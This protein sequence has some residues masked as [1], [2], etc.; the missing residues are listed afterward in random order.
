MRWYSLLLI[1]PVAPAA[2][3]TSTCSDGWICVEEVAT[4]N[5][6]ELHARNL[7]EVPVTYTLTVR[8]EGADR[9]VGEETVTHTLRPHDRQRA[10]ALEADGDE[11][12]R[13]YSI[14]IAWSV[15]DQFANHDDDYVYALPYAAGRAFRVLQ[16]Y[17][18]RLTHRGREEYAIDFE[19]PERTPVHAARAGIVARVVE[20][21]D[22]GC[23]T[24]GCDR[25]ANY[26]VILHGDGTTG[27]YYHLAKDGAVVAVGDRV[28]RGQK[29]GLSGNTGHSTRP[30]LHFGVYRATSTGQTQ[31]IPVRFSS[32]DGIVMRPRRGAFHQAVY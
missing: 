19:M 25:Y 31:S 30:H 8:T 27:E 3:A 23:A 17:R 14:S 10:M 22:L 26:I 6:I 7:R 9:V 32:A 28:S 29:I 24:D 11:P 2:H 21:H 5:A 13:R 16:G 18:S 1:F 12:D 15:G 20:E 4:G